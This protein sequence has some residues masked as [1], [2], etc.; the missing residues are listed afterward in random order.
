MRRFRNVLRLSADDLWLLV[1]AAVLVSNVRLGL[2]CLGYPRLRRVLAGMARARTGPGRR[3]TPSI[4]RTAWAVGAASRLV[5]R[6]TCLTQALAAQVLLRRQE[7]PARLCLG[8]ARGEAGQLEAHAWVECAGRV[9]IGGGGGDRYVP[10]PPAEFAVPRRPTSC[11][12][13]AGDL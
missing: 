6:A 11:R 1:S 7:H 13:T 8:V 2:S 10:L 3:A 5:P 12:R 9:V 4:E